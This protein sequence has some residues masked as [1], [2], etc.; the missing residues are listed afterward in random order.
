MFKANTLF[1]TYESHNANDGY[2]FVTFYRERAD[3]K[4]SYLKF[5]YTT[6]IANT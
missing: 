2:S 5:K 6:W 1:L 3:V 4:L